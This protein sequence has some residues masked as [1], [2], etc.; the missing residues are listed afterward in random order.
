[1]EKIVLKEVFS[2]T[3]K[4]TSGEERYFIKYFSEDIEEE[5]DYDTYSLYKNSFSK[6]LKKVRNEN[7]RKI[8]FKSLNEVMKNG[9]YI[10]LITEVEEIYTFKSEV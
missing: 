4:L 9:E 10:E 1:M 8:D 7:Y 5:I 2:I 6:P 3:K